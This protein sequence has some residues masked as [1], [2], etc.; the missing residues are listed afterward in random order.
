MGAVS[1]TDVQSTVEEAPDSLH[2]DATSV[3]LCVYHVYRARRDDDVIDV[4]VRSGYAAIVQRDRVAS[5][6]P[7]EVRREEFLAAGTLVPCCCRLWFGREEFGDGRQTS[8]SL[9]DA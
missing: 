9:L 3:V 4:G 6:V 8:P 2:L 1:A 5:E 7:I